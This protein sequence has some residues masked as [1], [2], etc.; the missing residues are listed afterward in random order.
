MSWKV[1][2][3]LSPKSFKLSGELDCSLLAFAAASP[4]YEWS[5]DFGERFSTAFQV[6]SFSIFIFVNVT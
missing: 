3:C 4:Q 2:Q 6:I 5:W 1:L